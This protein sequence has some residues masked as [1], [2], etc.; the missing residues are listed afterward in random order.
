MHAARPSQVYL[1]SHF[2]GHAEL[3]TPLQYGARVSGKASTQAQV[4][5]RAH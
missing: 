1:R 3:T 2:Y 5:V 4:C